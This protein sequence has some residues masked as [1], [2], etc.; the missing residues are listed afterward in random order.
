MRKYGLQFNK[1]INNIN[2]IFK[3]DTNLYYFFLFFTLD[4]ILVMVGKV[5]T[6]ASLT[7]INFPKIS[8][9]APLNNRTSNTFNNNGT[10]PI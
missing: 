9:Q 7:K 5:I 3:R 4:D 1:T 2:T 6:S 10:K 8:E